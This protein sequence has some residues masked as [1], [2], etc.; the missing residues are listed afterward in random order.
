MPAEWKTLPGDRHA[1]DMLSRFLPLLGGLRGP[2]AVRLGDSYSVNPWTLRV[3]R[4]FLEPLMDT[5]VAEKATGL[6]RFT[7]RLKSAEYLLSS[8]GI[9]WNVAKTFI[10]AVVLGY[11]KEGGRLGER[12]ASILFVIAAAHAGWLLVIRPSENTYDGRRDLLSSVI[13]AAGFGL[14]VALASKGHQ[15][16]KAGGLSYASCLTISRAMIYLYGGA[17]LMYLATVVRTG[18]I[19]Y[20]FIRFCLV[21]KCCVDCPR[22]LR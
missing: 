4:G 18:R 1:A 16:E 5:D 2:A 12:Q 8:F 20:M 13:E 3:K 14:A 17:I 9:I 7:F 6:T 11:Y 10:M 15:G 19:P 22:Q 21:W